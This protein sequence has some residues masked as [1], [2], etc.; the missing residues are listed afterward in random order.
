MGNCV[1]LR[2]TLVSSAI[3]LHLI[4]CLYMNQGRAKVTYPVPLFNSLWYSKNLIHVLLPCM[5]ILSWRADL[6]SIIC[7]L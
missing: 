2:A 3:K 5:D 1:C 6:E 4:V 7:R